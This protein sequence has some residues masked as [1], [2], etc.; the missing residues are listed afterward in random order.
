M[1]PKQDSLRD[2]DRARRKA[3]IQRILALVTRQSL[4]LLSFEQVREQLH[5]RDRRFQGLQEV[6]LAQ[7]V[8]SVGRYQDFTR[9]FLPRTDG[10]RERWAA[11]ED[12]VKEGGL[13]PVELH[14]VGDAFFVR[15]GNHRVSIARAQGAS[16]IEAFVWKYPSLVPLSPADDLDDLLIKQGYVTFLEK[17]DLNKLRP[18]QHIELTAPG[19]YRDLLEH[20]AIHRYYLG[21]ELER[22]IAAEEAVSSWYD[23]VYQ[24]IIRAIHKQG[25]LQQFPGRTEADLYIWISRWQYELSEQYG[26]LISAEDAVDEFAERGDYDFTD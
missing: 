6:P 12:R 26:E 1:S 18:D 13:P 7:I 9:T 17:T 5:L 23:N 10:L 15:D 21:Q 16:D 2:F 14:K 11:V 4:D 25:I 20:I 3:F 24:S 8:G 19:R 22:E